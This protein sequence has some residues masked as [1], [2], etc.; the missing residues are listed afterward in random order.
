MPNPAFDA[1]PA[2]RSVIAAPL[3]SSS[4][5][6]PMS[7]KFVLAGYDFDCYDKYFCLKP[8]ILLVVAAL[9]LC[10]DVVLPLLVAALA[11][12][13]VSNSNSDFVVG[14]GR[15][16]TSVASALPAALVLYALLAR[17]PTASRF[18]RWISSQGRLLLGASAGVQLLLLYSEN[19]VSLG[20]GSS[21]SEV[22]LAMMAVDLIILCYIAFSRRVRDTFRDF[23]AQEPG[24]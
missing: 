18:V 17:V 14:S 19:H 6:V 23:P 22:S 15:Q 2:Q 10:R 9:L 16:W 7:D 4:G 24:A 3:K 5:L 20:S 8:P 1:V 12:F 11:V 13:G 21:V